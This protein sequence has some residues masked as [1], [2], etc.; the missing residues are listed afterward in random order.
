MLSN[1]FLS[2]ECK[3][4]IPQDKKEKGNVSKKRLLRNLSDP[5]RFKVDETKI[6]V[7]E[8]K[9][10]EGIAIISDKISQS[11]LRFRKEA[12]FASK[13]LDNGNEDERISMRAFESSQVINH[14]LLSTYYH[15][16]QINF[17]INVI[18]E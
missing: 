6:S 10:D 11:S 3:F 18:S 12:I 9:D 1:F 14:Y 15:H 7:E 5:L 4:F 17:D 2:R 16:Y 8:S 13:D